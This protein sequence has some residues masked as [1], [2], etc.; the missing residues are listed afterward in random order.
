[1][2]TTDKTE[3]FQKQDRESGRLN[4]FVMCEVGYRYIP[5]E[6]YHTPRCHLPMQR[7][8]LNVQIPCDDEDVR[9]ALMEWFGDG[10]FGNRWDIVDI[11]CFRA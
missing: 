8:R 2:K 11:E 3:Q 4:K 7:M 5:P 1:M 6:E 10:F 9:D